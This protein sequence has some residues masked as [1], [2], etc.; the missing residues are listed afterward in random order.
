MTEGRSRRPGPR[1]EE[2]ARVAGVSKSTV[3]RVINGEKYVSE[4]SRQAV[5]RAIAM[6]GYS[7]NHAART[8]AG[9]KANAIALVISEQGSRVLADPFFAGVLRGVHAELAGRHVQLLLMMNQPLDGEDQ[10]AY[11]TGGHVDGALVVSLHG[12]D[13]LPRTLHE[14]G[15]PIVVGGRPL[16]G[17]SVPFVD[18]DNF[19]GALGAVRFLISLGR[20]KIATIAGPVD[21]AVGMDR[22]SGWRCG[23]AEHGMGVELVVHSDFTPDSG[24]LAMEELLRRAPDLDAVFVAADIMALGALRVLQARGYRIPDDVAVVGFDDSVLASTAVP[25]L[26]TVRQDVEG[27][28]RTLTWRLLA[29]LAGEEKLPQSMLLPTSLVRRS[30][31]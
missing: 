8:L 28:G 7:P 20:E 2:V 23:L 22:L 21:M 5:H 19:N 17:G 15:L 12:E 29:E 9:S 6:L 10:I 18:A 27:F 24:A 3:S 1:I 13:P 30:S 16:A 11:L 14:T 31:A 4:R 26:T 25:P